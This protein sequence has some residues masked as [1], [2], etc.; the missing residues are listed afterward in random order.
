M[1]ISVFVDSQDKRGIRLY[2]RGRDDNLFRTSLFDVLCSV[3]FFP[4]ESGRFD[5]YGYAQVF[6]GEIS[7]VLF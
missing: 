6:P 7:R 5:D 3:L 1:V 4:E 2:G